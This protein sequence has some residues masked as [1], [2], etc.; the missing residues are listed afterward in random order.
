MKVTTQKKH[1][2]EK[3]TSRAFTSTK[4]H[5]EPHSATV[6][7]T[8]CQANTSALSAPSLRFIFQDLFLSRV[9]TSG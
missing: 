2:E 6:K 9:C 4:V 7:A 5:V 1:T 8:Q 3:G